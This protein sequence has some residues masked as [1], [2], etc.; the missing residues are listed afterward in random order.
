MLLCDK[1]QEFNKVAVKGLKDYKTKN[2]NRQ[3]NIQKIL[4][5]KKINM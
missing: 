4:L 5:R 3:V 2:Y 1:L